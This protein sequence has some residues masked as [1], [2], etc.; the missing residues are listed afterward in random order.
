MQGP[1]ALNEV[2]HGQVLQSHEDEKG[3]RLG[4]RRRL[5]HP[6]EKGGREGQQVED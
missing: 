1:R 3:D 5:D 4:G 6:E 2:K